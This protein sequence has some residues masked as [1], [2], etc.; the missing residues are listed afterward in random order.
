MNTDRHDVRLVNQ[1]STYLI[2]VYSSVSALVA[3][4]EDF[5]QVQRDR[6]S[7]NLACRIA[8]GVDD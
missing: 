7:A 8:G 3:R 2:T 6:S 1:G 4:D 5:M